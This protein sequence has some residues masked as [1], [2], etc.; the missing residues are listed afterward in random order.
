MGSEGESKRKIVRTREREADRK[1][2]CKR[3]IKR[4]REGKET[5]RERKKRKGGGETKA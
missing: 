1:R 2:K 3:H 5:G 4:T